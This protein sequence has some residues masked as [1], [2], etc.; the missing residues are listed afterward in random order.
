MRK[1]N[2][3]LNSRNLEFVCLG[4]ILFAA[5]LLRLYQLGS[6]PSGLYYDEITSTYNPY[7]F[8]HGQL[9]LSP[10]SILIC[11]FSGSI[12][13]YGFAGSSAFWTRF[14][15]VIFGILLVVLCWA[16]GKTLFGARGG[17]IAGFLAA[18]VPWAFHFSRYG[19]SILMSYVFYVTLAAF[20]F[21]LYFKT[22]KEKYKF[23]AFVVVGISLY[24]HAQALFFDILFF[25]ALFVAG[26]KLNKISVRK[27]LVDSSLFFIIFAIMAMPFLVSYSSS[28]QKFSYVGT[29]IFSHSN[30]VLDFLNNVVTRI[31]LHLSPDFLI[32]SGGHSFAVSGGGFGQLIT[33]ASLYYYDTAGQIGMLNAYGVLFY[34]GIFW[35]LFEAV[36]NKKV[37]FSSFLLIWWIIS[38]VLVSAIASYDNPDPARNIEGLSAFILI[39]SLVVDKLWTLLFE[40]DKIR[41]LGRTIRKRFPTKLVKVV[42]LIALILPSTFFI[43]VYFKT[44]EHSYAYYDYDYK[45]LSAYFTEKNLWNYHLII[46]ETR[47]DKW[48]GLTI[49][50]F[51]HNPAPKNLV[52]GNILTALPLLDSG[53][54]VIYVTRAPSNDSGLTMVSSTLIGVVSYPDQTPVFMVW[55][56]TR[57]TRNLIFVTTSIEL[58]LSGYF[59]F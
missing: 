52:M 23:F 21:T 30:N 54:D 10:I 57:L 20:L 33:P 47:A 9:S 56:L 40:S 38:Y 2:F 12:F 28:P 4:L 41:I 48:Y 43:P 42:F 25:P 34:I 51:Y 59:S 3:E 58:S 55:N 5:L 22:K 17:L 45:L 35:L 26:C 24:T 31:Y 1:V 46:N 18:F 14:S 8:F 27:I 7:L 37:K 6:A 50:S 15:S 39:I 32:V 53:Y 13:T 11:F 36:K 16:F 49:L 19:V 29:T 44:F